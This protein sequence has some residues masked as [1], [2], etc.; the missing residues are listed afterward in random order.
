MNTQTNIQNISGPSLLETE[1]SLKNSIKIQRSILIES[2]SKP[3][4]SLAAKCTKK[5][6]QKEKLNRV[7]SKGF[8]KIPYCSSLYLMDT[9]GVQITANINELGEQNDYIGFDR[10]KR[11]Y[12][13]EFDTAKDF[14]LS[15]AYIS[16]NSSRPTITAVHV[17]KVENSIVALIGVDIKLADLP[18]STPLYLEPD[19]WRQI[20]GDPSIRG[21][22]FQQT[23]TESEWDKH[24]ATGICI[25]EELITQRGVFQSIIHFSSSRATV[26]TH[27]DPFQYRVLEVESL[28]DIDSCLAYPVRP[29][30]KDAKIAA[31][32]INAILNKLNTLRYADDTLYLRSASIN[33]FNGLISLTFSCDGSHYMRYDAFL[34]KEASFWG[35]EQEG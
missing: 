3:L 28:K 12:I 13:L 18:V 4:R 6:G 21:T 25:L 2:L 7:M 16:L 30:P 17:V 15:S 24:S 32:K 33:I 26:W 27:D 11:P 14:L 31:N 1:V 29:Y 34:Q 35:C 5:W 8:K 23:R 10:S 22:V 20:K 9:N 19:H